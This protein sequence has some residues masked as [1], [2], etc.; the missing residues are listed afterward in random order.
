MKVTIITKHCRYVVIE[1]FSLFKEHFDQYSTVIWHTV[2]SNSNVLCF[3]LFVSRTTS[4]SLL[5]STDSREV[6]TP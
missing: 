3:L 5:I 4:T 1:N 2:E 6:H